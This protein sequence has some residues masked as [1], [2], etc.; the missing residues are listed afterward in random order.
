MSSRAVPHLERALG[1]TLT[2][3]IASRSFV[4][5]STLIACAVSAQTVALPPAPVAHVPFPTGASFPLGEQIANL[6]ADPS[7]TRA[8]WGIAVTALDGTPIYGLDEGKLFRP[9]STNKLF[10][11]ATAM[12]L[13]GPSATVKTTVYF[14][15]PAADGTVTGDV[16]LVGSG[17]ANLSGRTIPF[18]RQ[19]TVVAGQPPPD[20]LRYIDELA[21]GVAR[22]G[23]RRVMGDVVA[24]DW[25]WE[26]YPQGWGTDDLLWGYGA[27]VSNLA[28][29][30]NE[31]LLT[32]T[33]GQLHESATVTL[34]PD[35]GYYRIQSTVKTTEGGSPGGVVTHRDAGE[36]ILYVDGLVPVGHPYATEIAVDDPPAYAAFALRKKL[37]EH[38][39]VVDGTVRA[40]H[41]FA[42]DPD[43]FLHESKMPLPAGIAGVSALGTYPPGPKPVVVT[44]VSPTLAEDVMVTL[45]ESQNLHAEMMLRRL[46]N[47]FG[48]VTGEQSSTFAQGARVVRQWLINAGIDGDDFTFYDGSG[49]SAKDVVTPR[50]QVQ[51]LAYATK[52]TWFPLWKAALPV[53]GIDGTLGSRFKDS[54]LKGHLFAK[55]G[56]LGESRA[57][58]GYV[59]CASG[60]QVIFSIMVDD[61]APG[62]SADHVVMDKIVAAIAAAN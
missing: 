9:A 13:L 10:T 44:H 59:D 24:S 33:P 34:T 40:G 8:H 15:P 54:S 47:A 30:D 58:A 14:Q 1:D 12:A 28:I 56:T 32:V 2:A 49:L 41:E 20:P 51:L 25:P 31:V 4:L 16:T 3:M 29:D 53:G 23:V 6:L 27:P 19:G 7:V 50:A 11:T 42:G 21:V 46:G 5:A 26:P 37:E 35:I 18:V 48:A 52:Q 36:K 39:I 55:T 38:G 45:K 22:A 61:H 60:R 57:L 62:S 17:D 43:N